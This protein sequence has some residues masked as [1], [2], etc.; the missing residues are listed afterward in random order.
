MRCVDLKYLLDSKEN[1]HIALSAV[2]GVRVCWND[3]PR[4]MLGK[5]LCSQSRVPEVVAASPNLQLLRSVKYSGSRSAS[6][7]ATRDGSTAWSTDTAA[8]WVKR[9]PIYEFHIHGKRASQ[10]VTGHVHAAKKNGTLTTCGVTLDTDCVR[11]STEMIC[12]LDERGIFISTFLFR[13]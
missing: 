2:S 3:V 4:D 6:L 1:R 10:D 9:E 13:K 5:G 8:L 11:T 12:T 7:R